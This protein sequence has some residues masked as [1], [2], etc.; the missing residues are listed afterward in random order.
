MSHHSQKQFWCVCVWVCVR[1]VT[2]SFHLK[3]KTTRNQ[4]PLCPPTP[5]K[6]SL[7]SSSWRINILVVIIVPFAPSAIEG[8][9]LMRSHQQI[10]NTYTTTPLKFI[11]GQWSCC[12]IIPTTTIF[13]WTGCDGMEWDGVGQGNKIMRLHYLEIKNNEKWST[14]LKYLCRNFFIS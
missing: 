11:G 9:A 12:V 8:M 10:L 5:M 3:H 2:P 14:V 4:I 13:E 7:L 1:S 6:P